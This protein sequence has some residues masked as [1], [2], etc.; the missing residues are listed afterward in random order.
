MIHLCWSSQPDHKHTQ[1]ECSADQAETDGGGGEQNNN[2]G[3]QLGEVHGE[4]ESGMERY[5]NL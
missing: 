3:V 2:A 1:H 5:L 4:M